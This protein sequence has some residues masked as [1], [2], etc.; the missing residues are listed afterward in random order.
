MYFEQ[1][2]D[3]VCIQFDKALRILHHIGTDSLRQNP[4]EVVEPSKLNATERK[5]SAGLMRINHAGEVCA[6]ALYHGQSLTAKLHTVRDKMNHAAQEE[7]E[8]LTWCKERLQQVN[9][10]T[11]YLNPMW[12]LG[13]F[14]IGATAG[15]ISDRW[16]LGF[17]AETERQV[18]K[19]LDGH[20]KR[21]PE[22]DRESRAIIIQMRA[23]EEK[24]REDA[25]AAGALEFPQMVRTAMKFTSRLMT[26]ITYWV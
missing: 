19:H 15:L 1:F 10:H 24:H 23:D 25:I 18:V 22:Q 16:S 26:K 21:L 2:L 11:S 3:K 12:Y 6:Q 4:A 20:M 7:I 5:V 14:I 17:V 9:S 8:H 13:S